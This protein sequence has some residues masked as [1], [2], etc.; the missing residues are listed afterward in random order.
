M[1]SEFVPCMCPLDWCACENQIHIDDYDTR[2]RNTI[3]CDE[4]QR[5]S[6]EELEE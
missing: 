5:G 6:H 4:C 1:S 3:V 2:D